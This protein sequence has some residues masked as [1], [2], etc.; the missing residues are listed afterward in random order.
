MIRRFTLSVFLCAL[1]TG[2]GSAGPAAAKETD[3]GKIRDG[4]YELTL[5]TGDAKRIMLDELTRDRDLNPDALYR[6]TT[7][8]YL[9]FNESDWVEK[10]EFKVFDIPVTAMPEYKKLANVLADINEK[11]S[12]IRQALRNYNQ[13]SL[14]L[15]KVCDK[16]LFPT[17]RSMDDN[18]SQ[19]LIVYRQLKALRELV[20]NSLDRLVRKRSCVDRFARYDRDLSIYT[21]RLTNLCKDFDRL[22]KK[23]VD[24]SEDAGASP[25]D[26]KSEKKKSAKK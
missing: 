5:K 6:V 1:L 24:R 18:I 8:G 20:A 4:V 2:V 17:L 22:K 15:M 11:I 7:S 16:S 14:R 10:L 9:G 25:K 3:T 12:S 26:K 21:K 19:Q 23:A 13:I